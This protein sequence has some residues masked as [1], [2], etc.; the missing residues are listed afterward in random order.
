M[1]RPGI[2]RTQQRGKKNPIP[3]LVAPT[4]CNKRHRN[5]PEHSVCL[6]T[7]LARRCPTRSTSSRN[8]TPNLLAL[9]LWFCPQTCVKM[10]HRDFYLSLSLS[11][12]LS[13][14]LQIFPENPMTFPDQ[15]ENVAPPAC[16]WSAGSPLSWLYPKSLLSV[17]ETSSGAGAL[18]HL[19]RLLSKT[20]SSDFFKAIFP[21]TATQYLVRTRLK[22]IR[23]ERHI[24]LLPLILWLGMTS[25]NEWNVPL[26]L[27]IHFMWP[28]CKESAESIWVLRKGRQNLHVDWVNCMSILLHL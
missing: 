21:Y 11:L 27:W 5:S 16:S 19:Q 6:D 7:L 14:C 23:H 26:V 28:P 22:T 15:M 3:G 24:T 9:P 8:T 18:H 10:Y 1:Y 4:L 13:C 25:H 17:Q 2:K 20:K 12:W